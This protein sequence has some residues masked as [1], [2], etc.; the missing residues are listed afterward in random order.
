MEQ[1][2]Q[3][4]ILKREPVEINGENYFLE[5]KPADL[6]ASLEDC[7]FIHKQ[8]E[9]TRNEVQS[10]LNEELK[11]REL[12]TI[13]DAKGETIGICSYIIYKE[14]T[15][16]GYYGDGHLTLSLVKEEYRRGKGI[17]YFVTKKAVDRIIEY[18]KKRTDFVPPVV[19]KAEAFTEGGLMLMGKIEGEYERKD[20]KFVVGSDR[21]LF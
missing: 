20:V 1:L 18:A 16:R 6:P 9:T 14:G 10:D 19:V 4:K 3:D 15:P 11:K 8:W 5:Y 12:E 17:G 21:L 2:Q 7:D 13:K